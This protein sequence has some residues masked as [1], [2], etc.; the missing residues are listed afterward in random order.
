MP[1]K[2]GGGERGTTHRY[3]TPG[4]G[5]YSGGCTPAVRIASSPSPQLADPL[6]HH[7]SGTGGGAH[8]QQLDRPH[9]RPVSSGRTRDVKGSYALELRTPC[10]RR[11]ASHPHKGDEVMEEV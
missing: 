7:E 4:L 11:P 5:D 2:R 1:R 9:G 10:A 3:S 8:L 6:N